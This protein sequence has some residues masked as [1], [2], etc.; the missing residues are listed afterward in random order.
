MFVIFTLCYDVVSSLQVIEE[1]LVEL[2]LR[3]TDGSGSDNAHPARSEIL[4][5][6]MT[7]SKFGTFL[8]GKTSNPGCVGQH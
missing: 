1:P 4:T 8:L 5:F 6:T 7:S 2:T 3:L